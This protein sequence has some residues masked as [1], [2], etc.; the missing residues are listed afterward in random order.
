MKKALAEVCPE[1]IS[2]WSPK[3]LPLKP[4]SI[5]YGSNEKVWWKGKCGHEWKASVKN[6]VIS[7]SGCPYCSH[8]EILVGLNDLASQ[9]SEIA[10]EWSK[11]NEPLLPTQVTVFANRKA[12]WKCKECYNECLIRLK[13]TATNSRSFLT[14][15]MSRYNMLRTFPRDRA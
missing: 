11:K 7:H 12:W 1:L 15:L 13:K 14:F 4:D 2:E 6:R 5:T 10:A 3:N 8:N 9:K